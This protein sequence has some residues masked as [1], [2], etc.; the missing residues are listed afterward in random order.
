MDILLKSPE[1]LTPRFGHIVIYRPWSI[2]YGRVHS[3]RCTDLTLLMIHNQRWPEVDLKIMIFKNSL[4]DKRLLFE[5][6][7]H[8]ENLKR[9]LCQGIFA[10]MQDL[11]IAKLRR[12]KQRDE[13]TTGL[14]KKKAYTL[15]GRTYRNLGK[16]KYLSIFKLTVTSGWSFLIRS[17][18][19]PF[20]TVDRL[21][22]RSD[23]FE[24]SRFPEYWLISL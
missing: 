6:Y 18:Y 11:A 8:K 21:F 7:V 19:L 2:D 16:W 4:T 5:L 24:A 20:Y 10:N 17:T 12:R 3:R 14:E 23:I 22:R 9:T 13:G 15:K 1:T